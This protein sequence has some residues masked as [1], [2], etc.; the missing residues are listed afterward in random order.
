M[1]LEISTS[2]SSGVILRKSDPSGKSDGK[3][4]PDYSSSALSL[5]I[6]SGAKKF[7]RTPLCQRCVDGIWKG[8]VVLSINSSHA[9]MG[10]NYKKRPL[11]IYDPSKAPVLDHYRLRVPRIRAWLEFANFILLLFFYVLALGQ[12]GNQS[13]TLN[14]TIFSIW[15]CGFALD[16]FAQLKEHGLDVYASS[17]FNLLDSVFCLISFS[18]FF[19]RI[20]SLHSGSSAQ[21]DFSFD[22][23]ALGAVLLCPRVASTLVQDNVVLLA[24]RAMFSDFLFFMALAIVI[25]SGFLYAFYS[26][27][28]REEWSLGGIAWLMLKIWFVSSFEI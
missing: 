5:A 4:L 7:I 20:F 3:D 8:H 16:E 18:W 19:L 22:L 25:F 1:G 14:E 6:H 15:L 17:L 11:S 27:S 10:D 26:L 12:K 21:S 23:L 9:L 2:E 24:L 13:W 28:D